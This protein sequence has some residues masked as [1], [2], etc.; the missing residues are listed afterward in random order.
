MGKTRIRLGSA[1]WRLA[2][3]IERAREAED[4]DEATLALRDL[5]RSLRAD[6]SGA[7]LSEALPAVLA[8][9]RAAA[10]AAYV[11]DGGSL[12]LCADAGL[13]RSLRDAIATLSLEVE[14]WFIAQTAAKKPGQAIALDVDSATSG[15]L[16]TDSG[17][18]A[19]WVQFVACAVWSGGAVQGVIVALLPEEDPARVAALEIACE[20]L[21]WHR[22]RTDAFERS[23]QPPAHPAPANAASERPTLEMRSPNQPKR[24]STPSPRDRE[25]ELAAQRLAARLGRTSESPS[26]VNA[27]L[28]GL[29][30]DETSAMSVMTFALANGIV[31]RKGSNLAAA[32][33]PL[34]L[35][36]D[37]DYETRHIIEGVLREEDF[38]VMTAADGR[39]ALEIA[40]RARPDF[41]ILDLVMPVMNGWQLLAELR[42]DPDLAGVPIAVASGSG[43]KKQL[44]LP[45]SANVLEK[46]LD[47]Y[48]LV[49]SIEG[50]LRDEANVRQVVVDC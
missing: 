9:V 23:R 22:A 50:A 28:K 41:I 42:A 3:G 21:A 8:A 25:L 26:A 49:T 6:C 31:E 29:G 30:H 44:K 27:I 45:E 39:A 36:V 20:L 7:V 46:P 47:F 19:G 5:S 34:V 11:V 37:D 17:Q 35:V 14:P 12:V 4:V 15:R 1:Q 13:P 2:V 16:A 38:D 24:S 10:G 40:R 32:R 33:R 48:R 18:R 43:S